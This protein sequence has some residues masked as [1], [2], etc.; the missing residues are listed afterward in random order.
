MEISGSESD[1]DS[2]PEIDR[3]TKLWTSHDCESDLDSEV[4]FESEFEISL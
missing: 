1:L 4:R 3:R 2:D